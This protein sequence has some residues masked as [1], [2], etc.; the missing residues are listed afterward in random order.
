M[1]IV[2]LKFSLNIVKNLI[3]YAYYFQFL[4]RGSSSSDGCFKN[5]MTEIHEYEGPIDVFTG[6]RFGYLLR[7]FDT[8]VRCEVAGAPDVPSDLLGRGG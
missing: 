3:T 8:Q 2:F 5:L 7:G 4:P 1:S 6:D